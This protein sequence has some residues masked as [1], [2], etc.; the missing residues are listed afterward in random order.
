[1]ITVAGLA[2][3]VLVDTLLAGFRAAAGRDGRIGK[4]PYYRAA[5]TRAALAGVLLVAA[6]AVLVAALVASAPDPH[7]AWQDLL[8]AGS[9]C[10]FVFGV[11][12]TITLMAIG[13]WL[14]PFAELR[15]LPT[16]VVLGP[17]TLIRPLVVTGGLLYAAIDTSTPRV[18]IVAI[19]AWA[20]MLGIEPLLGRAHASRWRRLVRTNQKQGRALAG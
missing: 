7:A 6:N 10:I 2:L 14:A 4:G 20:S 9:R 18:W 17:L 1:L 16:L 8:R 3:L 12:A 15:L 19:V 5:L 11:F 13:F